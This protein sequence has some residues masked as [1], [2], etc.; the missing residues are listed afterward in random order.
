MILPHLF[1]EIYISFLEKHYCTLPKCVELSEY[2]DSAHT[3]VKDPSLRCM[4][5]SDVYDRRGHDTRQFH[6]SCTACRKSAN[7]PGPV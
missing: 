6:P 3:E 2:T 7:L 1:Y 4:N 5:A